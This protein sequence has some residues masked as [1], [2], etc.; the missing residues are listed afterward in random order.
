MCHSSP[1]GYKKQ[2]HNHQSE[3]TRS[4]KR[5]VFQAA[6]AVAVRQIL[7]SP[8]H[9]SAQT[10]SQAALGSVEPDPIAGFR[11]VSNIIIIP[12]GLCKSHAKKGMTANNRQKYLS[13]G[14]VGYSC[15]G[16]LMAFEIL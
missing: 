14:G 13:R 11:H 7:A 3:S 16:L 2:R 1:D 4:W 5:T 9:S 12:G 6:A 15:W 8:S 10:Y